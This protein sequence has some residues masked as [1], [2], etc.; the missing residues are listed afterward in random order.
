M[1][2]KRWKPILNLGNGYMILHN[3]MKDEYNLASHYNADDNTWGQGHYCFS[4]D[5]CLAR[6]LRL[7]E[8][9]VAKSDRQLCNEFI[10][11]IMYDRLVEIASECLDIIKSGYTYSREE[12][13]ENFD[14]TAKEITYFGLKEEEEWDE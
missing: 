1:N 5:D 11:G 14:L 3:S 6:Y 13:I 12:L 8:H 2:N 10:N 7:R 9:K 4:V